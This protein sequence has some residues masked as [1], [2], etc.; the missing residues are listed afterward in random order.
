MLIDSRAEKVAY[1]ALPSSFCA[2]VNWG[3]EWLKSLAEQHGTIYVP[4]PDGVVHNNRVKD[5]LEACGV[6]HIAD[7]YEAPLFSVFANN[8]HGRS[9]RVTRRIFDRRG[10]FYDL[11]CPLVETGRSRLI[12]ALKAAREQGK[13][14]K[15][16]YVCKDPDH[17]EPRSFIDLA[18]NHIVPVTGPQVLID[19]KV[20][21]EEVYFADAQTTIN[22][23]K[24]LGMVAEHGGKFPGL[25]VAPQIDGCFATS[26]RQLALEK[27]QGTGMEKVFVFGS[28][29]SSNTSELVKIARAAGVPV[30]FL[31]R[32]YMLD[33]RMAAGFFRVG[34]HAGASVPLDDR[35]TAMSILGDLG[36]LTQDLRVADEPNTFSLKPRVY[37]FRD[38]IMTDTVR[39]LLATY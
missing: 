26:N 21:P 9:P 18:P 30:E 19:Y 10:L 1:R 4:N 35:D 17:P 20:Q 23:V 37:D 29:T 32:G 16:L 34:V 5:E 27:L 15:L 22:V 31:E 25:V 7:P 12:G 38:G 14:A 8:M 39:E 11:T 6:R 2:G 3:V 13:V 36:Y 24:S 33:K 28:A